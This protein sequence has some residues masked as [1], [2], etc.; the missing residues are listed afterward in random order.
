MERLF[1]ETD[2][3][4]QTLFIILSEKRKKA[5]QQEQQSTDQTNSFHNMTTFFNDV[6]LH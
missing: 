5:F 1:T 6:N 2:R 3:L 4:N